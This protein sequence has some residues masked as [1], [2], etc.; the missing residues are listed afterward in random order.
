MAQDPREAAAV[1]YPECKG[2]LQDPRHS[3]PR[4]VCPN[5]PR[6]NGKLLR[7]TASFGEERGR[8]VLGCLCA[9]LGEAGC[10]VL[11]E[12]WAQCELRT[13]TQRTHTEHWRG[14]GVGAGILVSL[15]TQF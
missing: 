13:I 14:V 4:I 1:G 2:A 3:D 11:V 8:T 12:G 6:R 15:D 10:C 5:S 9:G 7:Q